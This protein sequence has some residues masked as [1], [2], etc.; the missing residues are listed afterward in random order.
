MSTRPRADASLSGDDTFGL[1]MILAAVN[2]GTGPLLVGGSIGTT[3]NQI[4]SLVLVST[5][6]RPPK[7]SDS[8]N[9]STRRGTKNLRAVTARSLATA[10]E[11]HLGWACVACDGHRS[12]RIQVQSRGR[13]HRDP[14]A[15]PISLGVSDC[16]NHDA[17][18][19]THFWKGHGT[20]DIPG[21][22][23]SGPSRRRMGRLPRGL[24]R[25]IG[26][27]TTDHVLYAGATRP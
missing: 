21:S 9:F 1:R 5:A 22:L 18:P 7:V 13:D 20:P 26:R 6:T 17:I 19:G 10:G 3:G 8:E 4:C 14:I 23:V 12:R 15:V 2:I 11:S 25:G 27:R 24:S 16:S